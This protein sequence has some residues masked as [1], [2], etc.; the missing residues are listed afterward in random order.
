MGGPDPASLLTF[1]IAE[2]SDCWV[3]DLTSDAALDGLSFVVLTMA[4]CQFR[5][6]ASV[7]N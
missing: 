2:K 5:A 7:D 4:D 6:R 1:S 3:W